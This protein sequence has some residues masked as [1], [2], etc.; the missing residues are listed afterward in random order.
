[1][2]LYHLAVFLHI[3]GAFGL[4]A[5]LAIEAIALRGLR[6]ATQAESA[7]PWLGAIRALRIMAP[8]SIALILVMGLYLMATTWGGKPWI[9]TAILGLVA[10]AVIGGVLSGTRMARIGPAVGQARGAL[11]PDLQ[12]SLQDPILVLSSRV[13][14]ALVVGILFLMTLK[15]SWL[16]SIIVLVIAAALGVLA[17]QIGSRGRNELQPAS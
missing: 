5:A 4:V 16:A 15:P 10:V 12:R 1:M 7:R 17:S 11:S 8:A 13:R 2:D 9:L 14:L 3:L 6:D